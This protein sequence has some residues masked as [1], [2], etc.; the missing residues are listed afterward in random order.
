[1]VFDRSRFRSWIKTSHVRRNVHGEDLSAP[2]ARL[3]DTRFIED[4]ALIITWSKA[5][6]DKDMLINGQLS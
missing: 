5:H 6:I 1:V 2:S 4:E 3:R